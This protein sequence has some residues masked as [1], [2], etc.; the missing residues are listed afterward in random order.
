MLQRMWRY[1]IICIDCPWEK[2]GE[3]SMDLHRDIYEKLLDWKE[4]NTGKVLEVNGARQVG[5]TY[6]LTKF[7]RENYKKF[8]Y[9]NM[10]QT[11]G[12]EF[13][14]CLKEATSWKPGEKRVEKP[15]HKAFELFDSTFEDSRDTV[16]LIDEIQ[17][18]AEVFS[19]IRQFAREFEAHFIVT[20]SYLGKTFNKE[21]FLPAGDIDIFVLDTL[22]F[23]EFLDAAGKREIYESIDLYGESDH[24]DY[25]ELK[26]WYDIYCQIG[27]YPAVVQTYFE[28]GDVSQCQTV[29]QNIV[30]IFV[31]E[32]QRY[33]DNVL[34]IN[35]FEQIFPAIAQTM[36]REKKGSGDLTKDLSKIIYKEDTNKF[37]KTNI[38]KAI[39]WLYRSNIIGYCDR[40]NEGDFLDVTYDC[41]FYF[42][43]VGITRMFLTMASAGKD[44]I[45]GL[46]AETFVYRYLEEKIRSREI[47]GK[48]PMF[49]IYKD[50]EIDFMV[51]SNLN[52]CRYGIEVKS[53]RSIG[54]SANL[55]LENGRVDYLYLLKGD[56]YGGIEGKKRTVPIYLAGRVKFD[57]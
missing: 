36:A 5:K 51:K 25:D 28:T 10:I 6:I 56:T 9:I 42:K 46:I 29:L 38:N 44:T 52:D 15:L 50:G 11:S 45:D 16:V 1:T 14:V 17:E 47:S 8:F 7:A 26:K 54:K 33:F 2:A 30:D 20:G 18:S 24:S 53:G 40:I 23:G 55:L 22:S 35:L 48:S 12:A 19:L 34:E 43:D 41:R 49:G 37:T 3:S 13:S 32:T 39:A 57:N 31:D 27:G 4:K 21:Y